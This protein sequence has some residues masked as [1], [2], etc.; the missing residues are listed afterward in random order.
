MRHYQTDNAETV[1]V[2]EAARRLGVGRSTAYAAVARGEIPALR[3]GRRL[4]VPCAALDRL[5]RGETKVQP[6]PED[7]GGGDAP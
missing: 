2:G 5:L 6:R 4:V 3:F 1:S 7:E